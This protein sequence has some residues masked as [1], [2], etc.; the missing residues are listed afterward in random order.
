M[1]YGLNPQTRRI[2]EHYGMTEWI[3][4]MEERDRL[5]KLASGKTEAA[6]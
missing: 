1:N 4:K 3:E 2:L 5:A 6:G